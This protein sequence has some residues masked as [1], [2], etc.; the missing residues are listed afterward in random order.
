[1]RKL[2][3]VSAVL[4]LLNTVSLADLYLQGVGT[5]H[6]L[7]STTDRFYTGADKAFIGQGYDWSG[8]GEDS[9]GQWATMISPSYFISANHYHPGPGDT[10]TFC[11]GNSTSSPSYSFTVASGVEIGTSDLY[12]G[13][14]S[15]PIPAADD[16]ASYPIWSL[17]TLSAY[18][19][20]DMFVYGTP[21]K[22]GRNVISFVSSTQI[23]YTFSATGGDGPDEAYLMSGD[24]GGPSFGYVNGQ[25]AV[26]GVHW[27]N[28]GSTPYDGATCSDTFVGSYISALQAAMV[29]ETLSTTSLT[30]TTYKWSVSGGNWSAGGNWS[31]AG[32]PCALDTATFNLG[33]TPMVVN[34]D[35][36]PTVACVGLSGAGALVVNG[37]LLT[38]SSA[39]TVG[40]GQTLQGGGSISAPA[41]NVNGGTLGG[42]LSLTGNV[43][44]V[45]GHITPGGG[46]KMTVT[47]SLTL[48]SASAVNFQ[49]G[50]P[51]G[52]NDQISITGNLT[53]DGTL[54]VAALTGFG[55]AAGSP[56]A[57]Y[58]LFTYAGTLTNDNP[59]IIM[60]ATQLNPV[61]GYY[62]TYSG[63]LVT[64]GSQVD[65]VVTLNGDANGDGILSAADLDALYK[66]Y[67][68][69]T[70]GLAAV[71]AELKNVFNCVMGDAN[72]DHK[73][74]MC[75]FQ[76]L[77]DHWMSSGSGIGWAQG[78]FNGDGQVDFS[79]FQVLLDNWNPAGFS[80]AAVPEPAS[81][82]LLLFG[83][84][85]ILR[86]SRKNV[87]RG[88]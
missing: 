6:E 9:A 68:N 3:V 79:D 77:L 51:G 47:G 31:P 59:K 58:P 64:T 29:G 23:Y 72:L 17:P 7:N 26:V 5:D 36:T 76:A 60:P 44:S 10:V 61:D 18:N 87:G 81:L 12:L 37:N 57:T 41:F 16:I 42:A 25:L 11:S 83:G 67:G 22:V 88:A 35:T 46:T 27:T 63:S 78:D 4:G 65:L 84:M 69:G 38:V 66:Q 71:K 1:M 8:V 75:D 34:V 62:Y 52:T 15:T 56:S 30:A 73:V 48:D 85:A 50:A 82:S 19:G 80:S 13:K 21:D 55:P 70:A 53:L 14:L 24:S 45:G 20:K 49:L 40:A 74:E 86:R 2:L 28:S 33:A 54:N 43:V 39:V 32:V